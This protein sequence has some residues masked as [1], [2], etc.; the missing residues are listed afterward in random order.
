MVKKLQAL[1]AKKG[2]TLVELIVVIAIIGVL[3]AILVPTM[4]GMVTKSR[5]T[6][7]DQTA[8]SL[9]T[10]ITTWMSDLESHN[11]TIPTAATAITITGHATTSGDTNVWSGTISANGFLAANDTAATSSPTTFVTGTGTKAGQ[12]LADTLANDYNFNN[13]IT[14]VVWVAGRKVVGCAYCDTS[15]D[16][17]TL[18]TNFGVANFRAAGHAWDGKTDGICGEIEGL[19]GRIVGTSPKLL[20]DNAE[21]VSAAASGDAT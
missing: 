4:M 21:S 18:S 12:K 15:V 5:V 6:S 1:K 14:V 10:T 11:G 17:S 9:V 19:S 7:A 13:D 16:A 8:S 3:A 2:F 20:I